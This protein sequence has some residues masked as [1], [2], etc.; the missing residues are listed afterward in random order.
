MSPAP[1]Q[2]AR[3]T[4]IARALDTL[5][6]LAARLYTGLEYR[7]RRAHART[8]VSKLSDRQLKDAGLDRWSICGCVPTIEVKAGLITSLMA[9]R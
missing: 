3:L 4:P 8:I 2:T 7:R 6:N 9:M 5:L 1:Q